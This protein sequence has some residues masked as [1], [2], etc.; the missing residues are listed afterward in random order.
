MISPKKKTGARRQ[1]PD[2][3]KKKGVKNEQHNNQTRKKTILTYDSR[4]RQ[5]DGVKKFV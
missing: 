5:L 4:W 3:D 1:T 2:H